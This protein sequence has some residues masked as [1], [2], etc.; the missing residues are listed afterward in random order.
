MNNK[1]GTTDASTE[2][3]VWWTSERAWHYGTGEFMR[4]SNACVVPTTDGKFIAETM[5]PPFTQKY[6]TLEQAKRVVEMIVAAS[7]EYIEALDAVEDRVLSDIERRAS[8]RP[9]FSLGDRGTARKREEESATGLG[10][11]S[12]G[13]G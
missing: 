2:R 10:E 6:D 8:E 3:Y 11:L 7:Y 12:G 13:A 4:F 1:E 9:D 5:M